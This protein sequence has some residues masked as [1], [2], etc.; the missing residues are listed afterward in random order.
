MKQQNAQTQETSMQ[1]IPPAEAL[2]T[3]VEQP[4]RSLSAL[5][6]PSPSAGSP[7]AQ[8]PGAEPAAAP[9]PPLLPSST[10]SAKSDELAVGENELATLKA[11]L[12]ELRQALRLSAWRAEVAKAAAEHNVPTALAERLLEPQFDAEGRPAGVEEQL[13]RWLSEHPYLRRTSAPSLAVTNP[14]RPAALTS[15]T[16]R[17]MSPE[18]IN[19]NWEVVAK[20]LSGSA[21]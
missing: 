9:P 4:D 21:T 15:E 1:E 14:A 7:L 5:S 17:N 13:Q 18:E 2:S 3:S 19:A 16:L 10:S 8:P 12:D 20:I 11:Q 6:P